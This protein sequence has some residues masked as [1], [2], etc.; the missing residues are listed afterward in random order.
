MRD[1]VSRGQGVPNRLA[2]GGGT[3]KVDLLVPVAEV[4]VAESF[5]TSLQ[6]PSRWAPVVKQILRPDGPLGG[7][8]QG[9]KC[10][11]QGFYSRGNS[12]RG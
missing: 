7:G 6:N 11:P 5:S 3:Q 9:E 1:P 12:P 10:R 2:V 4:L 8:S